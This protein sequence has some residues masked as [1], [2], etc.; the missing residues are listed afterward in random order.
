MRLK[1]V[2]FEIWF[3]GENESFNI[4]FV[5]ND[6]IVKGMSFS[7]KSYKIKFSGTPI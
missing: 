4:E 7:I 6:I 5:S 2:R 3:D 1:K